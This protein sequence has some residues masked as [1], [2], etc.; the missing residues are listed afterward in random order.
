MHGS[1]PISQRIGKGQPGNPLENG[2][3]QTW[4]GRDMTSGVHSSALKGDGTQ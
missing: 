2:N 1:V 4:K 3:G